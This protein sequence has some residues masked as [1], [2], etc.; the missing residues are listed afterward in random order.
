M[1]IPIE[2]HPGSLRR[3]VEKN[4]DILAGVKI[5]DYEQWPSSR[6]GAAFFGGECDQPEPRSESAG[7]AR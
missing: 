7:L 4:H 6:G 5:C 2:D 1:A 3:L